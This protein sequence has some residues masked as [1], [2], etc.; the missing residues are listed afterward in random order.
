MNVYIITTSDFPLG[1][2]DTK[3]Q[4]YLAKM[5][6]NQGVNC[7][8]VPFK[9]NRR[10]QSA[11]TDGIIEGISYHYSSSKVCRSNNP[12]KSRY[13]DIIDRILLCKYLYRSIT[14]GDVIFVY[15]T[16]Y[17]RIIPFLAKLKKSKIVFH[18]SEYP[19]IGNPDSLRSRICRKVLMNYL[20]SKADGISVISSALESYFK[21]EIHTDIPIHR[22]PILIDYQL[23]NMQSRSEESDFPYIFHAGSL[24]EAKDGFLGMV[25]AFGI[26]VN[27]HKESTLRFISTGT[28]D[29]CPNKQLLT[30]IIREYGIED[31]II[32]TGYVSDDDLKN[33]LQFA[34]IVIINKNDTLQNR[35]CFPFKLA[36]YMA[37]HKAIIITRVGEAMNWLHDKSDCLV[38]DPNNPHQICDAIEN[39]Y[40]DKSLS[41]YIANNASTLCQE[42]FDYRLHGASFVSFL[43][44]C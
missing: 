22:L 38:I 26:F 33:Y 27:K 2:A 11:P 42:N 3:Y 30:S 39:L 4:L 28:I 13:Y 35:Y 12:L 10:N 23:Y 5:L 7:D 19:F 14:Q 1:M 8:I 36:E 37:A 29:K 18:F 31:K 9:R 6:K 25:E 17:T 40:Q 32:F 34:S 43:Q 20:Y 41:R 21:S 24:T 15:G 44:S 16:I